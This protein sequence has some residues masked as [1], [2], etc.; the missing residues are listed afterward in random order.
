MTVEKLV[1]GDEP[2]FIT[3]G[4]YPQSTLIT[5]LN[6][7]N[8]NSSHQ[9]IKDYVIE[10]FNE[11]MPEIIS[12]LKDIPKTLFPPTLGALCRMLSRGYPNS[13]YILHKID[14]LLKDLLASTYEKELLKPIVD[15]KPAKVISKTDNTIE[16]ID[17]YLDNCIT[18]HTFPK[19]DW[20]KTAIASTLTKKDRISLNDYYQDL[21]TQLNNS[22]D[23]YSLSKQNFEKY[24]TTVQGI[25]EAFSIVTERKPRALKPVDLSKLVSKVKYLEDCPNLGLK[26]INPVEILGAK[27]VLLF[28][29]KYRKLQL[30]IA[31]DKLT[32]RG[33]TIY[34]INKDISISKMVKF[35]LIIQNKFMVNGFEYVLGSF[36]LLKSKAGTPTGSLNEHT[37]I[38]KV[39]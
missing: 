39:F 17:G 3:T 33:S 2:T 19:K 18:T 30:I 23:E 4:I 26:S 9:Q 38:L 20:A 35:P 32:V 14:T 22:K 16:D 15:K 24:K 31:E 25:I 29:T 28:D 21:L 12:T 5:T 8:Y 13:N 37:L 6:W 10:Y 36:K 34:G 7:Y 1:Y 27:Y 11:A